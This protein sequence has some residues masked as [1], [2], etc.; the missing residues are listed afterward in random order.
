MLSYERCMKLLNDCVDYVGLGRNLSEQI[1][2]LLEIGFSSEELVK[3]FN[4]SEEDIERHLAGDDID[5]DED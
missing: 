4:F 1:D 3:Y 5:N 2:E